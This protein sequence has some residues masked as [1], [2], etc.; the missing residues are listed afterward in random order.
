LVNVLLL[1]RR[2]PEQ[3]LAWLG[4]EDLR[5]W[6]APEP[7]VWGLIACGFSLLIPGLEFFQ[8]AAINILLVIAACYFFQGLAVVAYFFHKGRVPYF[9]RMVTYVLIIFQQIFTLLIVGLGLFDLW[10]DFR[11]LKKKDLNP[12]QAS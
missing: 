6:N 4:V 1:C 5:E 8:T 7:L 11:R 3:R 2:F 9:L 12:S 10:G